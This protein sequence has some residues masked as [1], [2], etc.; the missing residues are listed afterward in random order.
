LVDADDYYLKFE[1]LFLKG[2]A[3]RERSLGPV[4]F[5]WAPSNSDFLTVD[6]LSIGLYRVSLLAKVGENYQETGSDAWVLFC[7]ASR[8]DALGSSYLNAVTLTQTWGTHVKPNTV[9]SFLRAE[10]DLLSKEAQ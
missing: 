8:Y 7:D 6:G 1:P 2:S 3:R 5:R 4:P 10:L 9:R